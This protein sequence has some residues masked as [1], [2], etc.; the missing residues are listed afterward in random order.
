MPPTK[1]DFAMTLSDAGIPLP[2]NWSKM[3]TDRAETWTRAQIDAKEVVEA[4]TRKG[5]VALAAAALGSIGAMLSV[6]GVPVTRAERLA[7]VGKK[8]NTGT[9]PRDPKWHK[10]VNGRDYPWPRRKNQFFVSR[11]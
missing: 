6:N 8:E 11:Y 4:T 2:P 7:A 3:T 9:M 1:Q 10:H 5:L